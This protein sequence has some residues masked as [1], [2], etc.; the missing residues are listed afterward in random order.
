MKIDAVFRLMP[1]GQIACCVSLENKGTCATHPDF[2][3]GTLL[4]TWERTLSVGSSI[5]VNIT[6][7][8]MR[9]AHVLNRIAHDLRTI[10]HG[11]YSKGY[12]SGMEAGYE[13][14]RR[15]LLPH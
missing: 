11:V 6:L 12:E 8:G 2:E 10:A 3:K 1:D 9:T 5:A 13:A 7:S 4:F 15:E 14:A